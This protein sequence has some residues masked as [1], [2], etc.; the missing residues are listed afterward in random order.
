VSGS[1]FL[2]TV[3]GL[4]A[5]TPYSFTVTASNSVGKGVPSVPSNTVTPTIL[6]KLKASIPTSLA[7]GDSLKV[8]AKLVRTD[9]KAALSGQPVLVYRRH[10]SKDAWHQI[11]K[12]STN[13]NG[14]ASVELTPHKSAHL[15]AVFPGHKGISRSATYKSYVVHPTVTGSLSAKKLT[16]GGTAAISGTVAPY[17][18]GQVVSRQR[19]VNSKWVTKDTT[20]VSDD[21]QYSFTITPAKAGTYVFR[22]VV[23]KSA[24]RGL[25]K[26]TRLTLTVS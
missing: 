5:G 25:G 4:T 9:T 21:G 10:A 1:N 13:D 8:T 16:V 19:L 2:A 24:Y 18:A 26:T 12:L 23:A 14:R 20:I 17:K 3:S 11:D 22:T 7:F 15:E 6:T